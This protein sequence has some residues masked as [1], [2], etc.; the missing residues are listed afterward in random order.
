MFRVDV[1][2]I[3]DQGSAARYLEEYVKI[4]R[5]S[6]LESLSSGVVLTEVKLI[7]FFF[8]FLAAVSIQFYPSFALILQTSRSPTLSNMKSLIL[9]SKQ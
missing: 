7:L 2:V 4:T 5:R 8:T 3:P 1:S 6:P 9:Y